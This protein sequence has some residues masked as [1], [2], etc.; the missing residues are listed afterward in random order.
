MI[1]KKMEQALNKQIN[2]EIFSSYLYLSM[3]TYFDANSLEGFGQFYKLQAQEEMVHAMKFFNHII[4]R[5]GTVN[6]QAIGE[7]KQEWTSALEAVEDALHHEEHISAC[8]NDLVVLA[9]E[10][11]DFAAEQL[12]NW[13]VDEQVEEEATQAGI[14]DQLKLIKSEGHGLLMIDR[15]VGGRAPG[16]NPYMKLSAQTGK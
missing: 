8:I 13:F 11:R 3:A 16:I 5:N 14:A 10:E 1:N 4:E 6:L 9:R 7:P 15:E 2:E 12:L